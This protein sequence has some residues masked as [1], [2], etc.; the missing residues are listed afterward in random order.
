MTATSDNAAEELPQ[1]IAAP[2]PA[3][4]NNPGYA[5]SDMPIT[6]GVPGGAASN[7]NQTTP[8]MD[9]NTRHGI[10]ERNPSIISAYFQKVLPLLTG[11]YLIRAFHT[12]SQ[13]GELDFFGL[14]ESTKQKVDNTIDAYML[15]PNEQTK[16]AAI[17]KLRAVGLTENKAQRDL[18]KSKKAYDKIRDVI[19][20]QKVKINDLDISLWNPQQARDL[21]DFK[22]LKKK[23]RKDAVTNLYEKSYDA[24]VG[25]ANLIMTAYHM[26]Q[27]RHDMLNLFAETVALECGKKA[28]EITWPDIKKSDNI[29]VQKTLTNYR[30]KN[31]I[32][33]ANDALFFLS[34][35][36]FIPGMPVR[37]RALPSGEM[38]IGFKGLS[39]LS[40][41]LFNKST[42]YEDTIQFVDEKVNPQHGIGALIHKS[43]IYRIY[44]KF[45]SVHDPKAMFRDVTI[46]QDEDHLDR[47]I[48][49]SIFVRIADL[50][51]NTYKYKNSMNSDN[52]QLE[53]FALPQFLY[54]LGHKLIDLRKPEQT[55]AYINIMNRYGV[56]AVKEAKSEFEFGASL[57]EVLKKYPVESPQV[58]EEKI[59]APAAAMPVFFPAN[60]ESMPEPANKPATQITS[61]AAEREMLSAANAPAITQG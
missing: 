60:R 38:A 59:A 15:E 54:L 3:P 32:R 36:A 37:L 17:N 21:E 47:N 40:D 8:V 23:T 24:A 29:I 57:A 51:N 31:G 10:V 39:L 46:H 58:R 33:L 12:W 30:R 45:A 43:D 13:R 11:R 9:P 44:Q 55:L 25:T 14:F 50:M 34:P 18:N 42:I 49:D 7:Q 41:V 53:N 1:P 61:I 2:L 27:T 5:P 56:D 52:A 6:K 22:E 48:V 20:Q 35:A 19:E 16:A 26:R 4:A 28:K